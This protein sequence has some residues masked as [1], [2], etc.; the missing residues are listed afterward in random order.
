M[1][2]ADIG[3]IGFM[4]VMVVAGLKFGILGPLSKIGGLVIGLLL[5]VQYHDQL[6]FAMTDQ[7]AGE[8]IRRVAA[9]AAILLGTFIVAK[10]A[11]SFV[12]RFLALLSL[13]W[14]DGLAGAVAGF[15][16]GGVLVGTVLYLLTGMGSGGIQ[17]MVEESQLAP[18]FT[19]ASV[20]SSSLPWCSEAGADAEN[21]LT[22]QALATDVFGKDLG[23][24][25]ADAIGFDVDQLTDIV[26]TALQS[27]KDELVNIVQEKAEEAIAEATASE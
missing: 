25:L 14:A 19:K 22:V 8:T 24:K 2:M 3:I 13:G 16:L 10:I 4:L 27:K 11:A 15:A 18:S 23:D 5:A 21:C 12:R 6:A 9:F 17:A 1:N 7:I 26:D 20:V